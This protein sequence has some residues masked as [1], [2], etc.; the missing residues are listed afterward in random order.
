MMFDTTSSAMG[1][2]KAGKFRPLAVMSRR[3]ARAEL[4]ERADAWP[5]PAITG[6]E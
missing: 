1:Q 5:R 2:I 6:A 4:P 3:S